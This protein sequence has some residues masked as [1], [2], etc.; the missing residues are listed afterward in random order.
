MRNFIRK[1]FGLKPKY[2]VKAWNHTFDYY[3]NLPYQ[4]LQLYWY[5][6]WKWHARLLNG[7]DI[8]EVKD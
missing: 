6:Y 5:N 7:K 8:I 1:L 2:R 4:P 3:T